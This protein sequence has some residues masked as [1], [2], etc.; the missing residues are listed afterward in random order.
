MRDGGRPGDYRLTRHSGKEAVDVDLAKT[1]RESDMLLRR[2]LLVAKE[3][4]PVFAKRPPDL[5]HSCPARRRRQIDAGNLGADRDGE[6][7]HLD[8]IV[9]HAHLPRLFQ[10]DPAGLLESTRRERLCG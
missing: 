4:N 1:A 3:H 7:R 2:Q 6:R 5:N 9:G 8:V 10:L